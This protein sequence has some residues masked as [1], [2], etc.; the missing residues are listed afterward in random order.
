MYKAK[1][2][3]RSP[4]VTAEAFFMSCCT[5][6]M[7]QLDAAA[8]DV[9]G[10]IMQ[11]DIDKVIHVQLAGP[12]ATLL[13]KVDPEKHEEWEVIEDGKPIMCV[14]LKKALS[15]T[16]QAALLDMGFK[17]SPH[18]ECVCNKMIIGSQCTVLWHVDD[19]K[20]SQ[21]CPKIVSRII[22]EL[23]KKHGNVTP[24]TAQQGKVHEYLGMTIDFS[25]D[26]QVKVS[27]DNFA[28]DILHEAQIIC[29]K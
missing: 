17:L 4:T 12:L 7:D 11:A 22:K 13:K 10:A 1:E 9:L 28:E 8:V 5:D 23:N 3:T 18:D 6:V 20:I 16:L 29:L 19:L 25:E 2:E 15:G 24:L 14:K 27:M 26:G 21:K